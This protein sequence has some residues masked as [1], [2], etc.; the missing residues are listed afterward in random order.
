MLP[1]SPAR[2]PARRARP[3]VAA[4]AVLATLS[5]AACGGGDEAAAEKTPTQ[6]LAAA[7][8]QFDD[9]ASVR[10]ELS[11]D[12]V[13]EAGNGVL[14]ASGVVT[15]A[16]AFEGDV[17]VLLSGITATVPVTSVGG[18]VYA[19]LPLTTKYAA[20]DPEEYGAP[21]PAD[22]G[23]PDQGLSSLLTEVEGAKKGE[24]TRDGDQV[25]TTYSGTLPGASVKRIVPSADARS[26]YPT[27]VGVD[28]SGQATSVTITGPFFSDGADVTYDV[29]FSQ[30]DRDVTIAKPTS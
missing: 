22:F 11:T 12:S 16:P 2:R 26:D 14:G 25:L 29:G 6:V 17:K 27:K 3:L 4:V 13:P 30:Y 20:I 1:P 5:L 28:D 18:T 19:K 9:A 24:Q 21:D 23:D 15:D 10:I 8:K 7:K